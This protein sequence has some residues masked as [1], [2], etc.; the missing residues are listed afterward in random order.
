MSPWSSSGWIAIDDLV[1]AKRR[2]GVL[3]GE[4]EIG[5]AGGR[6]DGSGG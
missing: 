3:D 2:E 4:V 5:L 1:R 6:L